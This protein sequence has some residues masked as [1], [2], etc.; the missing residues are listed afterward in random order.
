MIISQLIFDVALETYNEE[1]MEK[2]TPDWAVVWGQENMTHMSDNEL[3]DY[4]GYDDLF[5]FLEDSEISLNDVS[6]EGTGRCKN[7][8]LLV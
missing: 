2:G 6:V 5:Q 8:C 7:G 4:L 1:C 3:L